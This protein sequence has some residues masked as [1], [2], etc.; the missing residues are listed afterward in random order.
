MAQQ[1]QK[2]GKIVAVYDDWTVSDTAFEQPNSDAA[3]WVTNIINW[4]HGGRGGNFLVATNNICFQGSSLPAT[5]RNNGGTF[6][7]GT[8]LPADLSQ[9]D[10]IFI[11]SMPLD[12]TTL[13]NYVNAG[14]CVY[15]AG[16]TSNDGSTWSSFLG[17]FGMSFANSADS[18]AG[19]AAITP[20]NPVHPVLQGVRTLYFANGTQLSVTTNPPA[21]THVAGLW[22]SKNAVAICDVGLQTDTWSDGVIQITHTY[23]KSIREN[24]IITGG[25][26]TIKNLTT[27]LTVSNLALSLDVDI[28]DDNM[29]WAAYTCDAAGNSK[30]FRMVPLSSALAPGQS[31]TTTYNYTTAPRGDLVPAPTMAVNVNVMPQYSITYDRSRPVGTI[32]ASASATARQDAAITTY[33]N[34]IADV[35]NIIQISALKYV[36]TIAETNLDSSGTRMIGGAATTFTATLL[37]PIKQATISVA[38]YPEDNCATWDTTSCDPSGN[39]VETGYL[40]PAQQVTLDQRSAQFSYQYNLEAWNSPPVPQDFTFFLHLLPQ[41]HVSYLGQAAF[42]S[43]VQATP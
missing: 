30:K 16:G 5:V 10:G 40:P 41:I 23:R 31:V 39:D 14:G 32:S 4:F 24:F 13:L 17:Q 28:A 9:Y 38:V 42:T 20:T 2:W 1:Q 19:N 26:V 34:A 29:N 12:N 15:V 43:R 25:T 37:V 11:C 7:R 8:S 18:W 3:T 21:G 6:T 27:Q 36:P 22:G 35:D 33:P